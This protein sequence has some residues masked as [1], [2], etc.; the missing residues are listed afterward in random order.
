MNAIFANISR[1]QK[2][3]C[4]I[5]LL[6]IAVL[7]LTLRFMYRVYSYLFSSSFIEQ[8]QLVF[9]HPDPPSKIVDFSRRFCVNLRY[10]TLLNRNELWLKFPQQKIFYWISMKRK[11]FFICYIF[12]LNSFAWPCFAPTLLP[13]T[14]SD[15]ISFCFALLF[16]KNAVD[17]CNAVTA[18]FLS[19]FSN[20][21]QHQFSFGTKLNLTIFRPSPKWFRANN[22]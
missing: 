8:L 16:Q 12:Q 13:N 9:F 14:K 21:K 2:V 6:P 4:A 10:T 1:N 7:C 20:L 19:C 5:L 3:F 22:L 15:E 11:K 17:G 18:S